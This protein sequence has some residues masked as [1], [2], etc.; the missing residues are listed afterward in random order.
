LGGFDRLVSTDVH[1]GMNVNP[2]DILCMVVFGIKNLSAFRYV[3]AHTIK[4][5]QISVLH[6]D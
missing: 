1:V 5:P 4:H 3:I 2:D 6:I